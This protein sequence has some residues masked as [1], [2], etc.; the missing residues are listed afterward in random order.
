M[1]FDQIREQAGLIQRGTGGDRKKLTLRLW[2]D[3]I[4]RHTWISWR[5]AELKDEA[6]VAL[7]AGTSV[8]MIHE[9]YLQWLDGKSV[10]ALAGMRPAIQPQKTA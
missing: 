6:Q 4:C 5:L 1:A 2:Q 9:H 3:D 8:Q 10:K 7:E